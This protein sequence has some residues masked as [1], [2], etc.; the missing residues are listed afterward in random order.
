M[1]GNSSFRPIH[2]QSNNRYLFSGGLLMHLQLPNQVLVPVEIVR[3]KRE[4]TISINVIDGALR[5]LAPKLLSSDQIQKIIDGK[6]DWI[7][8]KIHEYRV[9][10]AIEQKKYVDGEVFLYLGRKYRLKC[11]ENNDS[12]RGV[13]LRAGSLYSVIETGLNDESQRNH[14]KNQINDWYREKADSYLKKRTY[15]YGRIMGFLPNKVMVKHYKT[16]WGSCSASGDIKYD[17]RIVIAPKQVV[18]YLVIHELSHLR[19]R[20][21]RSEFWRYLA[22]Y[23]ANYR[24]QRSWLRDNGHTLVV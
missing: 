19:Y 1:N 3:T 23:A 24:E 4:K 18:D 11:V 7:A 10:S 21:H 6:S 2:L 5:V 12:E 17:W 13:N 14:H 20:G 8:K 9:R 15:F 22:H 16:R